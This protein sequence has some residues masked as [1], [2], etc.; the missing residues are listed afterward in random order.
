MTIK[1]KKILGRFYNSSLNTFLKHAFRPCSLKKLY[2]VLEKTVTV[3][4]VNDAMKAASN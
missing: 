2:S 3:D 1:V 4:E